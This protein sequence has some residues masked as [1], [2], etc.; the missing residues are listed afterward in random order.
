MPGCSLKGLLAC[1]MC[2]GLVACGGPQGDPA[3][4]RSPEPELRYSSTF[5]ARLRVIEGCVALVTGPDALDREADVAIG[6]A[7]IPLFIDTFEVEAS[8]GQLKITTP[9]GEVL[10]DGDL[11]LGEG[12]PW[13]KSDP[14]SAPV[15]NPPDL[16]RCPGDPYQVVGLSKG[17][18]PYDPEGLLD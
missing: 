4:Y 16:S 9:D 12:G 6:D 13:P 10:T 15:S 1:A 18:G 11:V 3:W 7:A 8:G 17:W 2:A 5:G 14:R